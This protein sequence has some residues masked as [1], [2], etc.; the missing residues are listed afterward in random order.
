MSLLV[1]YIN[2]IAINSAIE[3]KAS[4]VVASIIR[5]APV[6]RSMAAVN[7]QSLSPARLFKSDF[8]IL[9]R[10]TAR[11]PHLVRGM[12]SIGKQYG[13]IIAQIV[14]QIVISLDKSLLPCGIKLARDHLGLAKLHVHPRQELDQGGTG[15]A[16]A[17]GPFDPLAYRGGS[18]WQ[19]LRHP[20]FQCVLLRRRQFA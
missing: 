13:F 16:H 3:L 20:V 18:P 10:P 1:G 12:H 5:V 19:R 17:I 9:R 8:G 11:W 15:I 6:S 14:E 2:V 7:V 4:I